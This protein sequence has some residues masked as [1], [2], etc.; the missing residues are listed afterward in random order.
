MM[1]LNQIKPR[2]AYFC[3]EYGLSEEMPIYAGGLGVLA[4]DYLK[5]ARDAE[6]P[7]LGIGILWANDY[8]EQYIDENG[9]PYDRY[10]NYKYDMVKDTGISVNVRIRGEDVECKVK[11]VDCYGNAPLYLLDTN[12]PGSRHGWMTSKLYGGEAQ[13][14]I[15]AEMILGIGGVRLIRALGWEAD[16]YHF[17]EGHAVF[18]G[19][20]LIREKM[21]ENKMSFNEAWQKVKSQV[22]FTTHTPVEAGNEV[23]DHGLLQHMEA[24]NGLT[25]EEMCQL[26]GDPFNM[27]A[28]ALRISQKANAASKLHGHT[29]RKMWRNIKLSSPIIS[30]TNG[31]HEK[32]WQD[33][34]IKKVFDQGGDLWEVHIQCKKELFAYIEEKTGQK[35]DPDILTVGFARRTASYKRSD[36][37]FRNTDL[38]DPY[39][40][41]GK[42][43]LIFSGK[44]HPNDA[45]GKEIITDLVKMDR[46][47]GRAVVFLENYNMEVA[48]LL[49]RGCDVW[50]NNPRRPFEASGT[51]GMKA[52]MN[53]VINF[54]VVDGWV[55]E[56]PQHGISGWLLEQAAKQ[57][58]VW[59]QDEKD[60][61]ELYQVLFNEIIPT[62]YYQKE[63]WRE[64]MLSSID[65]AQ[66]QFSSARMIKEYY[67][68]IYVPVFQ[69]Q[70]EITTSPYVFNQ[71]WLEEHPQPYGSQ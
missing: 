23:H 60:L 35:L 54:S 70:G 10:P 56:G 33:Q 43:Q 48:K 44:A 37:I 17:N 41:K 38:L 12:F 31:V 25:Y 69:A 26:G 8:T 67:D 53:G 27:T 11:L 20:E 3:M 62:Y 7:V 14:R 15:A 66:W 36:L 32:T 68:V 49:V 29:A 64:M 63:R 50:L 4:G 40:S 61:Q 6:L 59:D 13:D 2:V 16:L 71:V 52:A 18:V 24:Y 57:S 47:Y 58:E 45:L 19:L 39:L 42:L 30:I 34:R 65:M 1:N 5:A 9:R 22:V 21:T 28:A 55:A 51:S 46:K